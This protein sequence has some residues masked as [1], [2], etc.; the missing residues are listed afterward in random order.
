MTDVGRPRSVG[1]ID[2]WGVRDR[3]LHWWGR[4]WPGSD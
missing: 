2:A 4:I 3:L 1:R